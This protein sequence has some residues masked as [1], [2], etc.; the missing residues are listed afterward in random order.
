MD[1]IL[2]Q[3]STLIEGPLSRNSV[4]HLV[5]LRHARH[6]IACIVRSPVHLVSDVRWPLLLKTASIEYLLNLLAFARLRPCF[7]VST[8]AVLFTVS[9]IDFVVFKQER[10]HSALVEMLA[11]ER[12]RRV[13]LVL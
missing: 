3:L 5:E 13:V 11:G 4:S 2:R 8:V 10:K 7:L 1:N 12:C 6:L 9:R